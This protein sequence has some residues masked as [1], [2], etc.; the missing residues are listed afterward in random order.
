MSTR[1]QARRAWC[2]FFPP[3]RLS[4]TPCNLWTT[5]TVQHTMLG[6]VLLG[7]DLDALLTLIL[8]LFFRGVLLDD[9]WIT[10]L[11]CDLWVLYRRIQICSSWAPKRSLHQIMT[12]LASW[13]LT[14]CG[15]RRPKTSLWW[16]LLNNDFCSIFLLFTGGGYSIL[17]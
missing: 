3:W 14:R 15:D 5:K 10:H 1:D 13:L 6:S 7:K 11:M 2:G 8:G 17:V 9:K 16:F 12:E 4:R